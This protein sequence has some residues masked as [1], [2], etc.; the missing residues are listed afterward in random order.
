MQNI[1]PWTWPVTMTWDQGLANEAQ[2]LADSVAGGA[3]PPGRKFKFQ[4]STSKEPFFAGGLDT[5]KYTICAK[6]NAATSE[7]GRW[8]SHSNGTARQGIFYQTGMAQTAHDCK[9]KLG[10]GK[11]DMGANDVMWVLIFGE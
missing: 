2:Q 5:A 9:T 7:D 4:N 3:T 8:F 1:Q 6:S 11:T 10:V